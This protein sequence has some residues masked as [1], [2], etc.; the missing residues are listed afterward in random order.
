MLKHGIPKLQFLD[1]KSEC[2]VAASS[3]IHLWRQAAT[4]WLIIHILMRW[5]PIPCILQEVYLRFSVNRLDISDW[6]KYSLSLAIYHTKA[7]AVTTSYSS[8]R[9]A[10]WQPRPIRRLLCAAIGNCSCG[11]VILT[12]H[13]NSRIQD[14]RV[15]IIVL[16]NILVVKVRTLVDQNYTQCRD[17]PRVD[18]R[19]GRSSSSCAFK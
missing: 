17:P 18:F 8:W 10:H 6:F 15:V 16:D 3:D 4:K 7:T 11:W 2:L 1:V 14:C 5:L 12:R 9:G 13:L 19:W